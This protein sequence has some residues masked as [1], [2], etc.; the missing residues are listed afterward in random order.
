MAQLRSIKPLD[1][2]DFRLTDFS[3]PR[4]QGSQDGQAITRLIGFSLPTLGSK[5][6]PRWALA[7]SR[8]LME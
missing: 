7:P 4:R 6:L 1:A 8:Q 2:P 5:K 3:L